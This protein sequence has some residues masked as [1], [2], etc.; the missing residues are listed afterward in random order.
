MKFYTIINYIRIE[1]SL[2]IAI[3]SVNKILVKI[4]NFIKTSAY[5]LIKYS[6][7]YNYNKFYYKITTR[8]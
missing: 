3:I 1:R 6:I 5:N 2:L 7:L 4:T 8:V